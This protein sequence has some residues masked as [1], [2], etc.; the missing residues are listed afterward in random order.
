MNHIIFTVIPAF[1]E[2]STIHAV[3]EDV[4]KM[5]S[6]IIVVDDGSKDDTF[7]AAKAAGAMALRHIVNRGQ[8]AALQT[9]IASALRRGADIIVTFDADGQH[10]PD[11]IERLIEPILQK[12]AEVVLGARFLMP[13]ARIPFTR[14][15]VLRLALIHQWFFTGLRVTDTHCGLRAFSRKAAEKITITQDRMAHASEILEEI[16]R[17]GLSFIEAPV[18]VRYTERSLKKGQKNFFGSLKILYELFI[19]KFLSIKR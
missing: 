2:E 19:G 17:H 14:L 11:D 6:N 18:S 5:C 16:A 1:N 10:D 8:G 12:R 7:G 3:I 15:I 13:N 9:G 4:Q